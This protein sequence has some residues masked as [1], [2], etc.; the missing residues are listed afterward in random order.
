M[1]NCST[2]VYGTYFTEK[3]GI[4]SWDILLVEVTRYGKLL[5]KY[6]IKYRRD[7]IGPIFVPQVAAGV[8]W[9]NFFNKY[10]KTPSA[11]SLI[12]S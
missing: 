12:H 4:L 8:T 11:I 3:F 1:L 10:L 2:V 5:I 6:K 9:D 7:T